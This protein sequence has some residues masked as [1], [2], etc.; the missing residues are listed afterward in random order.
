[1]IAVP[2]LIERVVKLMRAENSEVPYYLYGRAVEIAE[3]LLV[4]DD[5]AVEKDK[6][7]PLVALR[8]DTPEQFV[9]GDIELT[10]NIAFL[11]YTD[12]DY[13]APDRFKNVIKPVLYPLYESF[14]VALVNSGLFYWDNMDEKPDHTKIDRPFWGVENGN[15]GNV[16]HIFNDPLD[17]VEIIDLKI[18]RR[19]SDCLIE[20]VS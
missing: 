2:D 5:D 16:E 3:R 20:N 7:Y 4:K 18:K 11:T 6:K 1:M 13:Y 12:E 14:F 19:D 17:A 9:D 15:K 10:L 8:L